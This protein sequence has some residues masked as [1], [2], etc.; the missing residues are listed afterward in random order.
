MSGTSSSEWRRYS[1]IGHGLLAAQPAAWLIGVCGLAG[2]WALWRGQKR[3]DPGAPVLLH[4]LLVGVGLFTVFVRPKLYH[5]VAALWPLLAVAAAVGLVTLLRSSAG[6]VRVTTCALLVVTMADGVV[7][8]TRLLQRAV[9]TTAYGAM[10]ARLAAQIPK[11]SR[12]LAL[13]HSWFGLASHVQDYRSLIATLVL[14]SGFEGQDPPIGQMLT[15][16]G[17]TVVLL[18]PPM[19]AFLTDA[20]DPGNPRHIYVNK[21]RGL[22]DYLARE[23]ERRVVVDDPSYGRFEIHYL[24]RQRPVP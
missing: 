6:L 4:A 10:C 2:L 23:S 12:L 16:T 21:A 15:D 14:A 7:A 8:W 1:P 19:L 20:M 24:R 17:A 18:D 13:P 5:Y 3:H 22:R 11:D 9:A